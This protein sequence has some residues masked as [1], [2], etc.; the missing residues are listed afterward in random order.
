MDN[1]STRNTAEVDNQM[2]EYEIPE[3]AVY[4][5]EL[6][7]KD[8]D[9]QQDLK[10]DPTGEKLRAKFHFEIR[11]DEDWEGTKISQF[12]NLTLNEQGYFRPVVE[13]LIGRELG[14]NEKVGWVDGESEEGFP[15][16]GIGNRRMMATIREDK[17]TDG[18]VF[19]KIESPFPVKTGGRKRAA[20]APAVESEPADVPF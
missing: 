2:P 11:D 7:G 15:I 6:V 9:F 5:L 1:W 17:K 16:V 3:T 8:P 4:M 19:P 12:Y 13:A 20:P 10:F 18:R 14:P